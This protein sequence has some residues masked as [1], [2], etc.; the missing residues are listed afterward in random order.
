MASITSPQEAAERYRERIKRLATTRTDAGITAWPGLT[1]LR[2]FT[3]EGHLCTKPPETSIVNIPGERGHASEF[4]IAAL[5]VHDLFDQLPSLTDTSP[6]SQLIIV[7]NICPGTL[8]LLG[9][10]YDIDPQFFAEHINVLS[11]Y[12]MYEKVP[13]RLPSLPSTKNAEDFHLLKYVETRELFVPDDAGSVISTD[14]RKTR[15]RQSAGK[16]KPISGPAA[17]KQIFP[18]MA[19][20]RQ[21]VSVWCQKKTKSDGWICMSSNFRPI[22]S[23]S[24]FYSNNATR[25]AISTQKKTRQLRP[26]RVPQPQPASKGE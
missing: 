13:E 21:T 3:E 11:W 2:V 15:I 6:S 8:A 25:S 12:Q 4:S 19:F 7:E 22:A 9:G 14:E 18:P 16:L 1:K 24:N 26:G 5:G 10:A 17:R 20:T 23:S